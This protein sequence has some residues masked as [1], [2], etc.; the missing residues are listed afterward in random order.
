MRKHGLIFAAVT[1]FA[2]TAIGFFF[3]ILRPRQQAG[4]I[5][6]LAD[7]DLE[8]VIAF[9]E[10]ANAAYHEVETFRREYGAHVQDGEFPDSGLRIYIDCEPE[11]K[12]QWVIVR[13]TANL[14]NIRSDLRFV[15]RDEHDLGISVHSGFDSALQECVP[16]VLDRLDRKR[17]VRITGHSLGASVAALM[18]AT[19]E[20]R[21]FGDVITITFG[22]PKFTDAHGAEALS[23]LAVLRIVHDDDPVPLLPPVIIDE[24]ELN[25]YDHCWPEVI[26]HADGHFHYLSEHSPE[27]MDVAGFWADLTELNPISHDMV[28]GYLPALKLAQERAAQDSPDP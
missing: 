22:Q 9:A 23:H 12:I 26:L 8:Q 7:V 6:D 4:I 10:R 16:W 5:D 14:P 17:P 25:S 15:G 24:D 28:K 1:L 21:G 2:I 20:K 11:G 27:R 3:I 18:H 13:G 19:L